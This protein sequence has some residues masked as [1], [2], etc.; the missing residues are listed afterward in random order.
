MI[1]NA[2]T[3][4]AHL[5]TEPGRLYV[6]VG[7]ETVMLDE[8]L[9]LLYAA[10]KT[11]STCDKPLEKISFWIEEAH[12][13]DKVALETHHYGMFSRTLVMDVKYH[14]T[15][16]DSKIKVFLS[17]FINQPFPDC[18]L[19]LQSPYINIKLLHPLFH[20][21]QDAHL[22]E[23]PMLKDK[24]LIQFIENRLRLEKLHY[25]KTI[26]NFIAQLTQ[27]NPLA[28]LQCISQLS[29]LIQPEQ[30]IEIDLV[31]QLLQDVAL[32]PLYTF[33]EACIEGNPERVVRLLH[34]LQQSRTESLLLLWWIVKIT[35]QLIE[36]QNNITQKYQ[37]AQTCKSL[38]IWSNQTDLYLRACKRLS[39][40]TLKNILN[41]CTEL[42]TQ[43]KSNTSDYIWDS[44]EQISLTFC[45]PSFPLSLS[46]TRDE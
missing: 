26:P 9:R 30:V 2:L 37:F 25:H 38:T 6:L 32:F 4:N 12:D 13:W 22:V 24:T 23:I 45:D 20:Q 33:T 43:L 14:K 40:Q 17:D 28:A 42:D 29:L 7:K 19:I 39:S 5:K 16:L 31:K 27:G 35:R 41:V 21:A 8:T 44:F 15:T 10:C 11:K 3:I 46:H 1:L 36:L 34:L 18:I